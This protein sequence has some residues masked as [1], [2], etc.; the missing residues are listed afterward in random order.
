MAKKFF[1]FVIAVLVVIGCIVLNH[2]NGG[3]TAGGGISLKEAND[4]TK[5][6]VVVIAD[7]NVSDEG[8]LAQTTAIAN[9]EHLY[10]NGFYLGADMIG[11]VS[12][13]F[14]VCAPTCDFRAG[15]DFNTFRLEFKAGNFIRNNVKTIGFDPQFQ[16]DLILF[17]ESASVNNA[18]QLAFIGK[19]TKVMVGHQGGDKFYSLKDGNYYVSAEQRIKNFS[20]SGG[21]NFTEKTTGYV[22]AKLTAKNNVVT[23]T[24]NNIG[25]ENHNYVLSYVR[26]NIDL[27]KGIMLNL[28]TAFCSQPEKQCLRLV[29][30]FSKGK[31]NLFAQVGSSFCQ[32]TVSPL[33]GL[34]ISQK[35]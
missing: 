26:N 16:N 32:G 4:T 27:G 13:Q 34:G 10:N 1:Y 9:W 35:L 5:A 17:G 28:G 2:K 12:T 3:M 20:L 23:A 18:M 24:F 25:A 15:A 19:T 29:T 8:Y 21:V 30:G 11:T 33:F 14:G 7:A 6:S 31:T 22:A